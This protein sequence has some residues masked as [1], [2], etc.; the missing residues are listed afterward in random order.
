MKKFQFILFA[1]FFL[2]AFQFNNHAS[3]NTLLDEDALNIGLYDAEKV[4]LQIFD[5]G[6]DPVDKKKKK[7]RR[8]SWMPVRLFE[9]GQWD[10]QLSL[11]T[12][13]TY[14]MDNAKILMPPVQAGMNYRISEHFSLGATIGHS[15]SESQPKEILMTSPNGEGGQGAMINA[16]WT[17]N[18]TFLNIR[19]GVHIT[20]LENWDFYGGFSIG[21][22]LVN[23][24]GNSVLAKERLMEIE[25]HLGIERHRSNISF[26]G[27]TGARRVV[28][29][30]FTVGAE[31]GSGISLFTV[32]AG[33]KIS[34]SKTDPVKDTIR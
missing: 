15:I 22:S 7:K 33:Y 14:V 21:A 5:T 25:S 6:D 28:S 31:I 11:G 32:G 13:P 10:A 9:K 2:I 16:T 17:N 1:S 12:V 30:R 18:S 34:K 4:N 3:A 26:S 8:N 29:P 19:P 27:F 20:K 24:N 23:I